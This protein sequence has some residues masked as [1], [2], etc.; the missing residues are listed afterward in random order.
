MTMYDAACR[1]DISVALVTDCK[2]LYDTPTKERVL[3]SDRRLSSEACILRQS[4]AHALIKWVKSEQMIS[5][6]LTKV[7]AGQNTRSTLTDNE[8]TLGPDENAK[9]HRDRKLQDPERVATE[10]E[11]VML[12]E[13]WIEFQKNLTDYNYEISTAISTKDPDIEQYVAEQALLV[14]AW[15]AEPVETSS[16]MRSSRLP[17]SLLLAIVSGASGILAVF[18]MWIFQQADIVTHT[19]TYSP[20]P[21]CKVCTEDTY[22]CVTC[23]MRFNI[24]DLVAF[25]IVTAMCCFAVM[26]FCSSTTRNESIDREAQGDYSSESPPRPSTTTSAPDFSSASRIEF[27]SGARMTVEAHLELIEAYGKIV[28]GTG[29]HADRTFKDVYEQDCWYRNRIVSKYR[30]TPQLTT[31]VFRLFGAYCALHGA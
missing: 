21:I 23:L 20:C 26:K 8:W 2:S 9:G 22:P 10:E 24:M 11:A 30:A 3:L 29:K 31:E 15:L 27:A 13:Q 18:V 25:I 1:H 28:F 19:T 4:L 7:M 5:D 12:T 14:E 6:C 17:T 16:V